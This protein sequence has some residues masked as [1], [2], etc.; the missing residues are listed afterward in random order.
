ME[1]D[2]ELIDILIILGAGLFAGFLNTVAG[3]GSLLTV[4][5]LIFMGLSPN[6]A[7]ATNRV[8]IFSQN[9]FSVA[10]FRSKGVSVFPYAF[11]L[12]LTALFGAILGA[13]IAVDI[14]GAVFNRILAVVMLLVLFLTIFR[15]GYSAEAIERLTRKHQVLGAIV[16]FFIGIYG[17]FI[18]AGVGFLIIT[19]ITSI[20]GLSLAK[21]NSIKVFVILVYTFAALAV[22]IYED[23][24]YWTIGITLAIGNSVGGWIASRWSADKGDKW[25]RI[26]LIVAVSA[27]AIKLWFF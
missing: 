11:W 1:I 14:D 19:A 23:Q 2:I 20:N 22:F 8:A 16:F 27:M 17:G 5:I 24:V 18:Q 21:T 12:S 26:I 7:N 15:P 6:I 3:G 25:I 10:G 9:I 13:Q 4:P